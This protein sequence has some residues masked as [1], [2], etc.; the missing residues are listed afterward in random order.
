MASRTKTREIT[1]VDE[2]GTFATFFKKF[3]GETTDYDFDG[4]AAVRKL[5]SNERA[6]LL[7]TIKKKN[8]R[9]LYELAKVL[10]RDFKSVKND[11]KLLEKFGC[12]DL[13]AEHT[14]K[15]ERLKP[16]LVIDTLNLTIKL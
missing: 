11:I 13:V 5:L 3:T 10:K 15:R 2:S 7:H 12:I 6:K 14:G 8:P 4:I 1:I 16:I 9:S